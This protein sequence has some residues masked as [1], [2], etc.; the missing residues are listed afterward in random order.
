[1]RIPALLLCIFASQTF[2]ATAPDFSREVRPILSQ[3]CF[4]CHGPDDKARKGGL[5]LDLRD[6]AMGE[7]KSG[8]VAVVPGKP[9]KSEL[10]ARIFSGDEDELMPPPSA[11]RPLTAEQKEILRRWIAAGAEYQQH[12]AFV[13]PNQ[14]AVPGIADFELLIAGWKKREPARAEEIGTQQSAISSWPRNAIDAFVL[15]RLL[16]AG[17]TPSP[18]ADAATLCRRLY[19]DLTGIPPSPAEQEEF[20][21]SAISNRQAAIESLVDK[22]LASPRYGERWARK[23]LDLARYADTNGYEK[24]RPRTI[25]PYRD[26]V[27][28]ALNAD[29]PFDQFT[30]EQIAGDMLPPAKAGALATVDQRIATGFHRN[31]MLNEEGGID[32][33]EFRFHAMTDRVA[34]TGVTWLGLTVGCA[35]C[36]THKF[37]PITQREYYQFMAFLNNADEPDVDLPQAGAGEQQRKNVE[38]VAKLIADLPGKFPVESA[39][40]Q[41]LRPS[42]VVAQSGQSAEVLDDASVRFPAEGLEKDSY[43]LV[44]ET[45]LPSVESLR[46]EAIADP[47]FPNQAPGRAKN[48]NFV[49]TEIGI[50]AAPKSGDSEVRPVRIARAEAAAQQPRF[51]AA[52]ALDGKQSTGWGV[53]LGD[54]KMAVNRSATFLFE[55]PVAFAGGTRL[56]VTLD[57]QFGGQH[58]LGR[59]RLS[60]PK[61]PQENA[62]IAAQRREV[63]DRRFG[64]WLERERERTARWQPLQPASA[65]SNLP[66]LTIETDGSIFASGDTSKSDTYEVVFRDV[67]AGVTSVLLEALPD[68]RLP[69]HGPGMAYYEG[70]K[71][72]FFLGEFQLSADGQPVKFSGATESYAKNNFGGNPVSAALAQDGDLQTG[73][74]TAGRMGERHTAVFNFS[75]PAP[76]AREWKFK[77]MMGRHY[78]CSLGRFRISITTDPK[79]AIARD[80]PAEV[81]ALLGLPGSELTAVQRG[82]LQEEFLLTLPELQKE[83]AEIRALRKPSEPPITL[84]FRER[85]PENPRPTFVH[86]RGEFLQPTEQ[87]EPGV[88]AF[89]N[90]LERG[91]SRDR[92]AFAR[93]LVSP[94]NPL[95]ARVTVNR[96]WAAFFGTGIVKTTEDFGY[97]GEAPT[98]P[99][100]LDWLAVEF[101]KQG[102]SLK[103][104]H[105]LIVTSATYRQSSHVSPALLNADPENRLLS[106][107]PRLRLEAEIIRD[108][109]LAASGLLADKIGG[110][111]VYPPQPDGVTEVAYGGGKWSASTGPDRH[112]RSLYTFS[113]RTAP[114]A[115]YNTFDGPT[116]EACIARRDV[117]NTAL[118]SLTL[119]ND[120]VFLEAAQALGRTL[121]AGAGST[122]ARVKDAFQRIVCRTA[123][124][125]EI[126][127]LVRFF[128]AQRARFAARGIEAAKLAGDGAG[129]TA[130]RAAWTALIRALFNLDEVVTRN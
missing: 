29:K 21:E 55:K 103:K 104:L 86:N 78:A 23:W 93:W 115:L 17:I 73:W 50:S 8:A 110:P 32:P 94:Q 43:T 120:V 124:V 99:E 87:V 38:L 6:S 67:P 95:T 81:E 102:W 82:R 57:Q 39:H 28:N 76:A 113:K 109:A 9:D 75:S 70:P 48:G 58:T 53:D 16:A 3:H 68:S 54:G 47:R 66:L 12:W 64:E 83:A 80:L 97:Q 62:E 112:R 26:W 1:M 105:R 11:K 14:A 10:V 49:L 128:E 129:V 34:T 24:D 108:A 119:L 118:Q 35:Q 40:W 123:S 126:A 101:V 92:L 106:R 33:L 61:P 88:P 122:E 96:Q 44:V 114:F 125:E 4:K 15:Q 84:G 5:R 22:L 72:D 100:L 7:A 41:T 56:T 20:L 51:Q 107:Y 46:L 71:G 111:S 52:D 25:W 79:G 85:P 2:A 27:I 69:K 36:H 74:S 37:D 31:T 13:K 117:S 59:F 121:A 130:E 116:G 91:A 18:E 42:S 98:H 63:L 89:L 45:D 60:V 30:I 77:L 65:K 90:P 127:A 19:L